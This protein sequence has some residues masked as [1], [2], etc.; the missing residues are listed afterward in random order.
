[1]AAVS[2]VNRVWC[3]RCF[4]LPCA[5]VSFIRRVGRRRVRWF[6]FAIASGACGAPPVPIPNELTSGRRPN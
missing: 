3:G 6:R 5:V 2:F 4:A 1:M